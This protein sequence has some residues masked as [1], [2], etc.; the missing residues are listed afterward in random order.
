MGAR[1]RH[2]AEDILLHSGDPILHG[3]L[4]H[5]SSREKGQSEDKP[6]LVMGRRHSPGSRA[7]L[8]PCSVP[9]AGGGVGGLGGAAR[10]QAGV[11][12]RT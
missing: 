7:D 5:S 6:R 12:G 3:E 9:G 10:S 1:A 11:S 4:V 8:Q 2:G